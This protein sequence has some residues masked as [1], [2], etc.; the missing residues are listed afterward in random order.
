MSL[1]VSG[2]GYSQPAYGL[3][4]TAVDTNG[5]AGRERAS[6]SIGG[7]N[8]DVTRNVKNIPGGNKVRDGQLYHDGSKPNDPGKRN[9]NGNNGHAANGGGKARTKD[10]RQKNGLKQQ[11]S[12]DRPGWLRDFGRSYDNSSEPSERGKRIHIGRDK[13]A[14]SSG[15]RQCDRT[16][17]LS[18]V[19]W[20]HIP[21]VWPL[22]TDWVVKALEHGRMLYQPEDVLRELLLKHMTLWLVTEKDTVVG[23]GVTQ[24]TTYP[25][26]KA[27]TILLIGGEGFET[28]EHF[29]DQLEAEAKVMGC[30]AIEGNGRLGWK[31]IAAKHGYEVI[32]T[33]FRKVL[34]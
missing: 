29:H 15:D 20:F 34:P 32:T 6:S 5:L 22:I 2:N 30:K 24:V 14:A 23:F 27:Y 9:L 17:V 11:S 19:D 12:D 8:Q 1:K 21:V 7:G 31:R 3:P 18:K 4:R 33:V 13:L 28:W 16:L 25:R 10:H 26:L